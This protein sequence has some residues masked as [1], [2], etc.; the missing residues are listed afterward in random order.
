MESDGER[1]D[2]ELQVVDDPSPAGST[3]S[4]DRQVCPRQTHTHTHTHT[5]NSTRLT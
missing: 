5:C 1:S 2:G 4:Y 3:S